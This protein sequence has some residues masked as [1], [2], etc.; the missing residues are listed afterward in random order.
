ML[1]LQQWSELSSRIEQNKGSEDRL[2][3]KNLESEFRER[4]V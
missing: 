3:H 1:K 4:R 2:E